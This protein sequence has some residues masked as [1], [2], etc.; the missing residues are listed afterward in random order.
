[1]A[2]LIHSNFKMIFGEKK[3][4]SSFYDNLPLKFFVSRCF[5]GML[6][7]FLKLTFVRRAC[8]GGAN[9]EFSSGGA[10]RQV[11]KSIGLCPK[12]PFPE[13]PLPET[14]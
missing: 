6:A 8:I 7:R 4:L 10:A 5:A 9:N 12:C 11:E 1:M 3:M 13:A 2:S 14:W